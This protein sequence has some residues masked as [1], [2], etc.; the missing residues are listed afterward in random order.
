[1]TTIQTMDALDGAL[2]NHIQDDFPMT[3]RPFAALAEKF[4]TDERTV[5]ERLQKAR[6][7]G[8]LRQVSAIFDTTAL[9]YRSSLVAAR[10]APERLAEGAVAISSHPGVSHNYRR[11]HDFNV[12]FTV[13]VPPEASLEW[14]VDRLGTLA[15]AESV[16][17]LP[18]LHLYK[19]G[20]SLDMTGERPLDARGEPEYSDERRKEASQVAVTP[21]DIELVR[22]LQDDIDLTPEPFARPAAAVGLSQERLLEEALRLQRQGHLRRF[23]AILRHRSAGFTANGMAV[24]AV[25]DERTDAIGPVMASFRAVS[26]C[27]RRP[28][29][30]DWPYSIFTMIHARSK[31]EC[32]ATADAIAE[33]TGVSER[34]MLYSSTEY[35]KVR[36]TYFTDEIDGWE[37]REREREVQEA[38]R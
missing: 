10:I 22:A 18:T 33:A 25:P 19:I 30:P 4:G 24:W 14:T 5:I 11:N 20:V 34:T 1:M 21:F 35:K 6:E 26:H 38:G 27:Y 31:A 37:R 36:L 12:W 16:R 17:R 9:G 29:Y 13:A 32:E 8:V 23:A 7:S 3:R 28:T 15:G 2:L